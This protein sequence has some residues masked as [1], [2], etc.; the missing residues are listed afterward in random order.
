ML[1]DRTG[2]QS[3]G[4][5]LQIQQIISYSYVLKNGHIE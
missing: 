1:R 3:I 4:H 2:M 5:I